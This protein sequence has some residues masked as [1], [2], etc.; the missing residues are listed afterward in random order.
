[1]M[2]ILWVLPTKPPGC[3]SQVFYFLFG[4]HSTNTL[5]VQGFVVSISRDIG[6]GDKN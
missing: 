1:M 5:Q 3:L 2:L 4:H 6:M